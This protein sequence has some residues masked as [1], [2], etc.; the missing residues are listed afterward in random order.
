MPSK[1]SIKTVVKQLTTQKKSLDTNLWKGDE[2]GAELLPEISEKLMKIAND[3]WEK[4]DQGGAELVDVI[5]TG[6]SAGYKWNPKSDLDLHLV[7]DTR[8]ASVL[9]DIIESYCRT[10]SKLWNREHSVE[11]GGHPL[12]IYVQHADDEHVSSSVY[13]IVNK[14][15][16]TGPGGLDEPPSEMAVMHKAAIVA[17]DIERLI[18]SIKSKP[19]E[20]KLQAAERLREKLREER[21]EGLDDEGEMSEENIAFKVVRSIGLLD[22][23][24][25][26]QREAYDKLVSVE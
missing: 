6:S 16:L 3:F 2:A 19:T 7:I 22:E 5:V 26:V 10:R 12:E 24:D 21:K 23:L 8:G 15:W 25:T 13:S 9:D 18:A 1:K 17:Q 14:Q 4:L 20:A 11:I